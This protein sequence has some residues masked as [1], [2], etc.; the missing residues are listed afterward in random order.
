MLGV[1]ITRRL[2]KRDELDSGEVAGVECRDAL[3]KS[4]VRIWTVEEL[5]TPSGELHAGKAEV[6]V[7]LP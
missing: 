5:E 3:Y 6:N 1:C 7:E 2:R 4:P